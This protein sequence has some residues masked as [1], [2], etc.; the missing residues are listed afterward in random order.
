MSLKLFPDY[1]ILI[2]TARNGDADSVACDILSIDDGRYVST[3]EEWLVSSIASGYD[4]KAF[5]LYDQ[6]VVA[7]VVKPLDKSA[8]LRGT[9]AKI[10]LCKGSALY[11]NKVCLINS[12]YISPAYPLDFPVVIFDRASL[13]P[14][15]VKMYTDSPG[16]GNPAQFTV[17]TGLAWEFR[18]CYFSL[19][20]SVV[21]GNRAPYVLLDIP[22]QPELSI[23]QSKTVQAASL[24]WR[25][26]FNTQWRFDNRVGTLVS[27][28]A[29]TIEIGVDGI[30]TIDTTNFDAGDDLGV[31]NMYARERIVI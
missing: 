18:S 23:S 31:V 9:F 22:G 14:P 15:P 4:Q 21:V 26:H 25:W 20:T 11:Y 5:Y 17:P 12:G 27:V 7:I 30:V 28:P 24:S 3:H 19:S 2:E 29:A 6:E 16:A 8:T 10:W 1:F 13:V